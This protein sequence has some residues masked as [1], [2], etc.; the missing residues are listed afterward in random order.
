M[1]LDTSQETYLET[2][3]TQFQT[4]RR[5]YFGRWPLRFPQMWKTRVQLVFWKAK[6]RGRFK[7]PIILHETK[8]NKWLTKRHN[9]II[10]PPKW[11]HKQSKKIKGG[12]NTNIKRRDLVRARK[13][14]YQRQDNDSIIL[15]SLQ[16]TLS[17]C[18]SHSSH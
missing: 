8:P 11:T 15:W 6:T 14:Q 17:K 2:Q 10:Q 4:T 3:K 7:R 9:R 1:S 16:E 13:I 5:A 18:P 12:L